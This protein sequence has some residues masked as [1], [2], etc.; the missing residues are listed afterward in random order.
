MRSITDL[1][2]TKK[3]DPIA[4]KCDFIFS[5]YQVPSIHG[6]IRDVSPDEK[7]AIVNKR[8]LSKVRATITNNH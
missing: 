6:I 3:L 8:A 1:N 4:A 7:G 5:A 2:C